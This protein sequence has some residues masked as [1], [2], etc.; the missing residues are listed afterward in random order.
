MAYVLSVRPHSPLKRSFSDNPYLNSCSPQKDSLLAPLSDIT[1]RN[2]SAC[3][4]YSLGAPRAGDWAPSNENTPPLTS[5][6]LLHLVPEKGGFPFNTRHVVQEPRKRNCGPDRPPPSFSRITAP[7]DQQARGYHR[8][9]H[10]AELFSE[11]DSLAEDM[12]IDNGD[13]DETHLFNLYEAIHVPL[14][15]GR[16]TD[17]DGNEIQEDCT[18]EP[19]AIA[20]SSQPFRRWVST[21]RRRHAQRWKEDLTE[22]PR[23]SFDTNDGMSVFSRPLG[24]LSASVGRTSGSMTSSMGYVTAMKSASMTIGST[25]LAPHS[26]AGL[27][28]KIRLGNRSSNYSDARRSIDSHRGALGPVLDE[29]AWLRS[30][31]RRKVVEELISSEES[32]IADLKVLINVCHLLT[33]LTRTNL[34]Y[35]GLFHDPYCPPYSI[36]PDTIIHTTEYLPNSTASRRLARRTSRG[37]TSGRF[38]QKRAPRDVSCDESQTHTF[39]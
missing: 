6:S 39:S 20:V 29:S 34:N 31:Q 37:C 13:F 25:S 18:K 15:Q 35:L 19:V 33:R 11:S 32:Y 10:T 24:S 16:F 1:A 23:L 30:L 8:S 2:G 3:S 5:Q 22:I 28:G 14:P 17:N 38:H 26:D 12:D 21:L 9:Q 27:H 7:P 4:L 36:G